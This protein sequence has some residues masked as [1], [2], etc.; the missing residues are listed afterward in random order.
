MKKY[1]N[2]L[3]VIVLFASACNLFQGD[4]KTTDSGLKY[5]FI[6]KNKDAQK[7][8]FGDVLDM[9]MIYTYKDSII[10]DSK[11]YGEFLSLQLLEPMYDGDISEGMSMLGL[12]D[13]AIF[14]VS[15]DS[16]YLNNIGLDSVPDF[17]EKGSELKFYISLLGIKKKEVYEREMQTLEQQKQALAQIQMQEEVEFRERYLRTNNITVQPQ[18]SGLYYIETTRGTGSKPLPGSFVQ[19]HYKG[20]LLDG[21]VFHSSYDENRPIS[22]KIGS[23]RIIDGFEEGI[24]LMSKG[25]KA[26]FIIP[27][28]LGYGGEELENIPPYSTLIYEVE[29]ISIE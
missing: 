15:A 20:Y 25:G 27:S 6:L 18:A 13:S 5:N 17:I 1:I 14:I 29:L 7:P 4:F 11:V 3:A 24:K 10:F 19:A 23:G 21:T 12:G 22:F 16:F 26:T 9:S 28:N 8:E 2:Y